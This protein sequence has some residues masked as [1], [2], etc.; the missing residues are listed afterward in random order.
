L[1]WLPIPERRVYN[2]LKLA[3]KAIYREDSPEY[4]QLQRHVPKKLLWSSV[5]TQLSITLVSGKTVQTI[6]KS[7]K[8][9]FERTRTE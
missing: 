1:G 3:E 9:P 4:L 7:P 5:D 2:L 6:F 8:G